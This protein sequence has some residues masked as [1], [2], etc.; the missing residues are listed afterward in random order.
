[1]GEPALDLKRYPTIPK[2]GWPASA[3]KGQSGGALYPVESVE[4]LPAGIGGALGKVAKMVGSVFNAIVGHIFVNITT[5]VALVA[6]R[7]LCRTTV[8]GKKNFGLAKNTLICSNHRTMIDSYLVGHLSSW[9]WSFLIP[10]KVPIHPAAAENF[11]GNPIMAWFSRRWN[12][13]P[14]RRGVKDFDA[15][16][17][18]EKALPTGQ[19]IIFPEGGRSRTGELKEGRPG[20]GKLIHD[21][22]CKVVPVYHSG[23]SEVLP[24]GA[25]WPR[26]FKRLHVYVGEP[27]NM[28]DLFE[29]P[30]SKET[31]KKVVGRVMEAIRALEQQAQADARK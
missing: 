22:R 25:K 18:M 15:L 1:M 4:V 30:S 24:I 21:T 31:S 19:M 6:Y 7:V 20:T 2:T 11:F 27:V 14:V 13:I 9:P 5:L 26:F 17:V 8:H 12:C 3:E 16:S 29:L 23:M 28:D 10:H